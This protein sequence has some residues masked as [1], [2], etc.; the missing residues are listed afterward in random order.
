MATY[1][2]RGPPPGCSGLPFGPERR[3]LGPHRLD[4][5]EKAAFWCVLTIAESHYLWSSRH[6]LVDPLWEVPAGQWM[7]PACGPG[8]WMSPVDDSIHCLPVPRLHA[9]ASSST[10]PGTSGAGGGPVLYK[11]DQHVITWERHSSLD[12]PPGGGR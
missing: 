7:C 10:K 1:R 4:A 9:A 8:Q 11:H 5:T 3:A 6:C 2:S 12:L